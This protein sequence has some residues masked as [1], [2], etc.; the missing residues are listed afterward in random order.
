MK[1]VA[2]LLALVIVA[3]GPAVP[4]LACIHQP[5]T[6]KGSIGTTAQEALIFYADGQEELI[7]K[8]N[9]KASDKELSSFAWIVTVPNEPTAYATAEGK[10]F[11]DTFTWAEK[12]LERPVKAEANN[13]GSLDKTD[14][15]EL[16][17]AVKV[18]PYDIQPV[19]GKGKDAVEGLNQWFTQ[20]GFNAMGADQLAY[21]AENNFT[22]LCVKIVAAKDEKELSVAGDLPPLQVSFKTD[23]P[24][25]P[26]KLFAAS[27]A[28]ELNMYVLTKKEFDYKAS[29]GALKKIGW[30]VKY[31][32][33]LMHNV[34]VN[35][36]AFPQT[37]KNVYQKSAFKGVNAKWFL[38]RIHVDKVNEGKALAKWKE[39]FFLKVKA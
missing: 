35:S 2:V 4:S 17:K 16:G 33:L 15:V 11:E 5:A 28:F 24:Y 36:N 29:E 1:L 23:A 25:L 31:S 13:L 6:Y 27:Q 8:V 39:D 21:F 3:A 19:R 18:G 10:V 37:L 9:Y 20:N 12:L 26:L 14:S 22:F 30:G 38:N 34:E 32:D 7:L